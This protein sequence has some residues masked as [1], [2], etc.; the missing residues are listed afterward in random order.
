MFEQQHANFSDY[1]AIPL[2]TPGKDRGVT[3]GNGE[4]HRRK[5]VQKTVGG[6][7]TRS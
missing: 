1:P 3:R 4:L 6:T 2:L 5:V 7:N